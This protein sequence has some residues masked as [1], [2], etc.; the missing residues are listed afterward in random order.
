MLK[1][2]YWFTYAS[3]QVAVNY[4]RKKK[5]ICIHIS[6]TKS[7]AHKNKTGNKFN[8]SLFVSIYFS[9]ANRL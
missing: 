8:F 5:C 6:I 7:K 9:S 2:A 1:Y 3:F 4:L